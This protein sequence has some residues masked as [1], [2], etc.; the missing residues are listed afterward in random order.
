MMPSD[1][2]F[3]SDHDHRKP[4]IISSPKTSFKQDN[5]YENS[6]KDNLEKRLKEQANKINELFDYKK[7]CEDRI[8]QLMPSHPIPVKETH[9][10]VLPKKF[11]ESIKANKDLENHNLKKELQNYKNVIIMKDQVNYILLRKSSN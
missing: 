11:E 4:V 10:K 5:Y 2:E 3:V 9:L 7:L 1:A 8:R 6:S